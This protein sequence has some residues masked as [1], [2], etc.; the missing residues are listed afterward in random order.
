MTG[1]QKNDR[2]DWVI[3]VTGRRNSN[4]PDHIR[5]GGKIR[6]VKE[7]KVTIISLQQRA[8][9]PHFLCAFT[10]HDAYVPCKQSTLLSLRAQVFTHMHQ[11][12]HTPYLRVLRC[13]CV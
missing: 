5:R 7:K 13:E 11:I 10:L 1:T 6:R 8:L 2:M 9:I 4:L 12:F 3:T